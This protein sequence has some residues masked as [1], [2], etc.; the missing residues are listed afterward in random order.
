MQ[1]PIRYS[2]TILPVCLPDDSD[3]KFKNEMVIV[4]GWGATLKTCAPNPCQKL[5]EQVE[6]E[7]IPN[8]ECKNGKWFI[9]SLNR[10]QIDPNDIDLQHILCAGKEKSKLISSDPMKSFHNGDSGGPLLM[11]SDDQVHTIIGVANASPENDAEYRE[12]P[13]TLSSRVT[14][15]LKWIKEAKKEKLGN[16]YNI[17]YSN[18][19][20]LFFSIW[21]FNLTN[22]IMSRIFLF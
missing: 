10:Q 4:A 6:I 13:S 20:L 1:D 16:Y 7:V 11:V 21:Y 12:G 9:D 22:S 17:S 5:L 14:S 3:R 15:F 18:K 8:K 2:T 19:F